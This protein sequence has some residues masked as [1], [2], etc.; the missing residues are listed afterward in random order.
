M[1]P[2]EVTTESPTDRIIRLLDTGLADALG[3]ERAQRWRLP[4]EQYQPS[5]H[6]ARDGD[7]ILGAAL[8]SA[9]PHTKAIKIV[10][11]F[12]TDEATE[13]LLL[14]EIVGAALASDQAAVKW[15]LAP[16][17][18]LPRCAI[19]K[20]FVSMKAPWSAKGTEAFSGAILWLKPTQ[21]QETGYYA[22]TTMFTCGAVAAL[23][24]M[25]SQ[26]HQGLDGGSQDRDKELSLW[27]LASNFPA[28]E[29]VGLGVAMAND[30]GDAALRVEI[31]S[32]HDGPV[33][34]EGF[35]GFEKEFR[36][37]LQAE[38]VAQAVSRSIPLRRDRVSI[39]ELATRL[40][41]GS[42]ALLLIDEYLMHN[43]H[44]PHWITAHAAYDSFIVVEAPWIGVEVGETW[45]DTHELPVAHADL[46]AM[47]TWG[48]N[49]LRGVIFVD[50]G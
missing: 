25:D 17:L 13:Q 18:T 43:D 21:H 29:P 39:D 40:S 30:I 3:A 28:C 32:D 26:G 45:V 9:R 16:G 47:I 50:K 8:T 44:G 35:E 38:S 46:D 12:A 14:D 27:R 11:L 31:A 49:A 33:L 15:E 20:G 36:E 23:I 6:V 42:A 37:V 1:S 24:A 22:Q 41:A 19:D 5:L 34:I 48:D 4:R 2:L 10:D 7:R